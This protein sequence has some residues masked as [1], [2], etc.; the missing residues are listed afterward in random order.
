MNDS[1][2]TLRRMLEGG[3]LDRASVER[4]R[5]ADRAEIERLLSAYLRP[6]EVARI[7]ARIDALVAALR[8]GSGPGPRGG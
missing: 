1:V 8:P 4:L 2:E 7:L 3:G 5:D 6:D